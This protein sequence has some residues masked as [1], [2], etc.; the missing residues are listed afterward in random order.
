MKN[1]TTK[2]LQI[3]QRLD[4]WAR[5]YT[6]LVAGELGYARLPIDEIIKVGCFVR[7]TG[8]R[9]TV[10]NT[11]AESMDAAL[12]ILRQDDPLRGKALYAYYLLPG[13]GSDH[14]R[15]LNVS[16]SAFTQYVQTAKVWLIAWFSAKGEL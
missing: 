14:A 2:L 6:Q 16:R 1:T 13:N 8:R 9:I 4:I 11:C 5:W 7:G 3:N 15:Q 12:Q 10:E